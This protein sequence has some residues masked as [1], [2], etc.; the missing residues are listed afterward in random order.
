MQRAWNRCP[1]GSAVHD[2]SGAHVLG[3]RVRLHLDDLAS[4]DLGTASIT[5]GL[6]VLLDGRSVD[7]GSSAHTDVIVLGEHP[8]VE[9]RRYVIADIHLSELLVELHLVVADLDALLEGD[10]EVVLSGI[11]GLGYAAVGAVCTDHHVHLAPAGR[12]E[13]GGPA[14]VGADLHAQPQPHPPPRPSPLT[15]FL[16][17]SMYAICASLSA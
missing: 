7:N 1:Q 14:G 13:H 15:A 3:D 11:D 16:T 10:G 6:L 9:V 17:R 5:H 4:L 12:V 2:A 8:C